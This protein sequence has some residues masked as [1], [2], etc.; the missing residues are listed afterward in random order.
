MKFQLKLLACGLGAIALAACLSRPLQAGGPVDFKVNT[1]EEA[2]GWF[3][4]VSGRWSMQGVDSGAVSGFVG[5]PDHWLHLEGDLGTI[6]IRAHIDP[7]TY[8]KTFEVTDGTGL[9]ESWVGAM[10]MWD[11]RGGGSRKGDCWNSSRSLQG[12]L[13]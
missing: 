5:F 9:Y 4:D 13:P 8:A 2:C 12:F 10:G 1:H 6:G 3:G 11:F 7:E